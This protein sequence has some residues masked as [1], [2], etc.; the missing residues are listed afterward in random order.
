MEAG[1]GATVSEL[2]DGRCA[3]MSPEEM[4]IAIAEACGFR[5][6]KTRHCDVQKFQLVPID[7][8]LGNYWVPCERPNL[9]DKRILWDGLPDHPNDLNAMQSAV[10]TQSKEFQRSFAHELERLCSDQHCDFHTLTAK[11]W[12]RCFIKALQSKRE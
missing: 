2:E 9:D 3:R 1:S 12:A 8:L 4:R 10:L 6:V 5:W 7:T 11:E